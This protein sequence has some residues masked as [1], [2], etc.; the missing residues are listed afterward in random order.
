MDNTVKRLRNCVHD[1]NPVNW[2]AW[3]HSI[4]NSIYGTKRPTQHKN[5][6][7]QPQAA[8]QLIFFLYDNAYKQNDM[9]VSTGAKKI[10]DL[11][12]LHLLRRI[13]PWRF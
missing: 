6:W 2:L 11:I 4:L 12:L 5:D 3:L 7:V 10:K 9:F 8:H 13:V 1:I